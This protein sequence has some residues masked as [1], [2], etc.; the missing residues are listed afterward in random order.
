M[1][2]G[3]RRRASRSRDALLTVFFREGPEDPEGIHVDRA[4][5]PDLPSVDGRVTYLTGQ[6]EMCPETQRL[7]Y[8]AYWRVKNPLGLQ[9]WVALVA[10]S[11]PGTK[12]AH[13]VF[14][15]GTPDQCIA[16]VTKDD[17]RVGIEPHEWGE[18]P[19]QGKRSD[20][21]DV[22]DA[23]VD[24]Q[25]LARIAREHPATYIRYHRGV[26]ALR[27]RTARQRQQPTRVYYLGGRT[28]AGK[29]T[30]CATAYDCE[31]VYWATDTDGKL[32]W[33]DEYDPVVHKVVIF[34]EVEPGYFSP[35]QFKRMFDRFPMQVA[36]KGG[37]AQFASEIAVITSNYSLEELFPG[38]RHAES[39]RAIV[40]RVHEIPL[41][42][43]GYVDPGLLPDCPQCVID[44]ASD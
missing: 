25:S 20:L 31:H 36:S 9:A 18:R 16:Y 22:A 21:Q 43:E 41:P 29:S 44:D 14:P 10:D 2:V 11:I 23:V 39:L 4:W 3:Q 30:A 33:L 32:K 28:G 40:R 42:D 27:S 37:H 35:S 24:G 12:P 19:E 13:V 15:N 34:D 1:Q 38:L 26:G 8:Q 5:Q 17:T 7:H 6:L